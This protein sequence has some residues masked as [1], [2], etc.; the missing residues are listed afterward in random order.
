MGVERGNVGMPRG[1][2]LVYCHGFECRLRT[3]IALSDADEKA[4]A[5][6][7]AS[8]RGSAAEERDAIGRADD[9]AS[10]IEDSDGKSMA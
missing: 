1:N 2:R 7:F 9:R 5:N 4:I 10:R 6:I 3:I 8:R